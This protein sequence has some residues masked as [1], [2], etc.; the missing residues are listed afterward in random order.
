MKEGESQKLMS[1][2]LHYNI[3]MLLSQKLLTQIGETVNFSVSIVVLLYKW[4]ATKLGLFKGKTEENK[5]E[6]TK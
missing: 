1:D 5:G 2:N 3:K 6:I 4:Q